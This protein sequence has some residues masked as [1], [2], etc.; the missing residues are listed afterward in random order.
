MI[1]ELDVYVVTPGDRQPLINYIRFWH[2]YKF[3]RDLD[4]HA[5]THVATEIA[6]EGVPTTT[7]WDTTTPFE[8]ESSSRPCAAVASWWELRNISVGKWWVKF[9]CS[10]AGTQSA[11]DL[12]YR[13]L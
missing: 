7:S 2:P 4:P 10:C 9:A 11:L 5:F 1:P 12:A 6:C 3:V 8:N 13:D